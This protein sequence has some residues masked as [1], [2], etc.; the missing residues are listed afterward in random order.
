MGCVS[1]IGFRQIGVVEAAVGEIRASTI[2]LSQIGF[3]KIHIFCQTFSESHFPQCQPDEGGIIQRAAG[4]VNRA[5]QVVFTPQGFHPINPD[6]FGIFKRD[7]REDTVF[8]FHQVQVTFFEDT[9]EKF[10]VVE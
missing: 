4:E 6:H 10:A 8:D 9:F 3:C 1:E 7:F 2:G 5:E